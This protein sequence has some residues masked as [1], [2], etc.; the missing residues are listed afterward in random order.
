M[1]AIEGCPYRCDKNYQAFDP[2]SGK[3]VP[4]PHC[5]PLL[6]QGI[7]EKIHT[8]T[9]LTEHYG[10]TL[11]DYRFDRVIPVQSLPYLD[12][13]SV[14]DFKDT[15][16]NVLQ[17]LRTPGV[18]L[19]H[20]YIFG[21]TEKGNSILLASSFVKAG[22]L[23]GID[24]SPLMTATEYNIAIEHD[25]FD[26]T[27]PVLKSSLTVIII[28]NGTSRS[29]IQAV[30]GLLE[31]RALHNLPTIVVTTWSMQATARLISWKENI[32]LD[33]CEP[34]F[35][36]YKKSKN[37]EQDWYIRGIV[38]LDTDDDSME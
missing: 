27:S 10:V 3:F 1:G 23:M 13:D 24:V 14:Q 12:E 33:Q 28:D 8:D 36:I 31:N 16:T 37:K 34:H 35:V 17:I 6:K 22:L 15:V 11:H 2:A 19:D 9:D 38:G 29:A 25:D 20:S 18:V 26:T 5:T 4:C 30:K 21:V 32:G 7:A